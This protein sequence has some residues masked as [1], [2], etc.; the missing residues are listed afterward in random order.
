MRNQRQKL[1]G[2]NCD[3]NSLDKLSSIHS[4]VHFRSHLEVE[5]L[6]IEGDRCVEVVDH[7]AVA[8]HL[9]RFGHGFSLGR[10][11]RW[12]P[13]AAATMKTSCTEATHVPRR[14]RG[15]SSPSWREASSF[16]RSSI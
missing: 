5:E 11:G 6:R 12:S 14:D 8:H 15:G 4:L 10:Q 13:R 2:Q 16:L 3:A 1:H 7:V 9:T